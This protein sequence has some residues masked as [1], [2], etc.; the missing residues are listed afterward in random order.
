MK[1]KLNWQV[2]KEILSLVLIAF[3]IAQPFIGAL[4]YASYGQPL[5]RPSEFSEN[6]SHT[7]GAGSSVSINTI[8]NFPLQGGERFPE[9]ILDP[10]DKTTAISETRQQY[11]Q[12]AT[13]RRPLRFIENRGQVD[14]RVKFYAKSGG[15]TIWLTDDEIV[16]DAVRAKRA[17]VSSKN[18][19]MKTGNALPLSLRGKAGA[20]AK[21]ETSAQKKEFERQVVRMKIKD[22]NA[23]ALI[24]GQGVQEGTVNYFIGNDPGKWKTNIPAYSE[25]YYK[26]IYAGIDM[27]FYSAKSGDME[28]DFIV[29][30]G[31][32]AEKITVAFEGIDG[33]QVD[34][35][36]DLIIKTAFGDMRQKAPH[37]YQT[38]DGSKNEIAGTFRIQNSDLETAAFFEYSF[39]LA[40]YQKEYAL[41][42]DPELVFYTYLGGSSSESAEGIA[43]DK[44]GNIY[45]TGS[46]GSSNFPTFNA[47]Y[48]TMYG[49]Y[50]IFV[51]KINPSGTAILYSTYIGGSSSESA[52]SI[53]VDSSGNAYLTGS[54]FSSDYPIQNAL[55]PNLNGGGD[56]FVTK[57]N[58]TGTS[59]IYSTYIGG[60]SFEYGYDLA[61]DESNCAV[62][63]GVTKSH[64]FPIKNALYP[65]LYGDSDYF[66]IKFNADGSDLVFGTY[67][68]GSGSEGDN[69]Q[70]FWGGNGIALDKY[71]NIYIAGTTDSSDFP[72]KNAL[73]GTYSGGD[74]AFVTKLTADG[75]ALLF[76]T[77]LGGSG[78]DVGNAIAVDNFGNAYVTGYTTSSNFPIRNAAYPNYHGMG[79]I[80]VSKIASDGANLLYSTY[81]GGSNGQWSMWS[82]LGNDIAVDSQGNAYITGRTSSLDFP[83]VN[84]LYPFGPVFL[85]K[86][87]DYGSVNYSTFIGDYY[88]AS[89]AVDNMGNAYVTGKTLGQGST[90]V[91][92]AIYP[93]YSGGWDAFVFK[94]GDGGG[95]EHNNSRLH[96][97]F[98]G[99][100]EKPC[101]NITN[102]FGILSHTL[103]GDLA[104]EK[105][106]NKF[107]NLGNVVSAKL[108]QIDIDEDNG[109]MTKADVAYFINKEKENMQPGDT[110]FIYIASH[111]GSIDGND[112]TTLTA[113]D[114]GLN[115]GNP[116]CLSRKDMDRN[117]ILTDDDLTSFLSGIDNNNKWIVLDAC[118]SGGFWGN[119]SS[120]DRGDLEKLKKTSLLA[121]APEDGVTVFYSD[122]ITYFGKALEWALSRNS[123]GHINADTSPRDG[124]V[125]LEEIYSAVH[126]CYSEKYKEHIGEIV[127]EQEFGTPIIYSADLLN[128]EIRKTDDFDS[129]LHNSFSPVSA[130]CVDS[131]NAV[132]SVIWPPNHKMVPVSLNVSIADNCVL[133]PSCKISSVGSNQGNSSLDDSG[134]SEDWQITGDLTLNLRAERNGQE[135]G[136][137]LYTIVVTCTD[138]DGNNAVKAVSVSVPHDQGRTP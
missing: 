5:K 41:V 39:A 77:Y 65:D 72:V 68:G 97:L 119:N 136:E 115:L 3:F 20:I 14:E 38:V 99:V 106:F 17:E 9:R 128:P 59:L 83:Q 13:G 87:N 94:M 52:N 131:V 101:W 28:Y 110:L 96:G 102:P 138:N 118:H 116:S 64:N 76:S 50:D 12:R 137:R 56:A 81:L 49:T 132:P 130:S 11:I 69:I 10:T 90:P 73:Y 91:K 8:G 66:V 123:E 57:I 75:S 89:V 47:L 133:A 24:N 37:I 30:P 29:H 70:H 79:D 95:P 43:V 60:S 42:I 63:T 135:K 7:T 1:R 19:D 53:A 126:Y 4:S 117:K 18:S 78:Q 104:A 109:G 48:P 82:T 112:E 33:M 61:V 127:F 36:G 80:F 45:V 67:L 21:M 114:E 129:I 103:R 26:D 107:S 51:T 34:D 111:G 62:V 85:T 134:T 113:E 22:A 74:D 16:F 27:R 121:A 125:T 35:K 54:T 25:V 40:S 71:G 84:S 32:D 105:V 2:P 86:F 122:G 93:N 108:L 124:N 6:K 100:K 120:S 98:I 31:A 44:S 58:A 88:G 23:R 15:T 92:N 46:T 55:Y